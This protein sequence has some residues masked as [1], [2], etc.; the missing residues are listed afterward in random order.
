MARWVKAKELLRMFK[1]T[2]TPVA[3]DS[4]AIGDLWVDTSVSPPTLNVCE[5]DSPVVFSAVGGGGGAPTTAQYVVLALNGSLTAE[6]VL[7]AGT[8]ISLVDAG[9]NGNVTINA[10]SYART[11]LAMG[12]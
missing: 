7:T 12:G 3:G 11:L 2:T 8:N 5:D 10:N 6:R 9:A 1:R 4:P